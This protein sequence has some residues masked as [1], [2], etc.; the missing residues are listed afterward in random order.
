MNWHGSASC[1]GIRMRGHADLPQCIECFFSFFLS[2][3]AADNVCHADAPGK[4]TERG[5]AAGGVSGLE[6][7][8]AG[9][10]GAPGE[11]SLS[12]HIVFPS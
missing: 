11:S 10:I 7:K 9:A 1:R 12:Y 3:R 5:H 4:A 6:R 8:A 2:F